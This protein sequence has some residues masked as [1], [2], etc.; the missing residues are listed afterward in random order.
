MYWLPKG[1]HCT[2]YR[3]KHKIS[4]LRFVFFHASWR[5]PIHILDYND[6]FTVG[7]EHFTNARKHLRQVWPLGLC[8]KFVQSSE[9][10]NIIIVQCGHL[11]G[12]G[13]CE[14]LEDHGN[15]RHLGDHRLRTSWRS[16]TVSRHCGRRGDIVDIAEI[17]DIAD[18][19][20]IMDIV[21]ILEITDIASIHRDHG[22]LWTFRT[23]RYV[24][25][26]YPENRNMYFIILWLIP[27][28]VYKTF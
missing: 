10:I 9:I 24:E 13:H 15:C 23:W 16:W 4:R 18:I 12:H 21:D 26:M 27:G 19:L 20:G 22:H 25:L 6:M 2:L 28:C 8:L 3:R 11:E 17:M 1:H 14:H 7:F 5:L